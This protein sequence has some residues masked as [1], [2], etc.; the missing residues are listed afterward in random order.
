MAPRITWLGKAADKIGADM[1]A[2]LTAEL[3]RTFPGA[4]G[5][6]VYDCFGGYTQNPRRRIVL[7]VEVRSRNAFHTHVVKIGTRDS[8][9]GDYDGWRTCILRHNCASRIFVSLDKRDLPGDRLAIIYEDA[10]KLFGSAEETQGPQTL[11]TVAFWAIHDGKPDPRSVERVIRQIYTD[12]YRWFYRSPSPDAATALAFYRRRLRRGLPK[13]D[14]ERWRLDLRRDLIWL[15]CGRD[16]PDAFR[17]VNYLDPCEYIAWALHHRRFPQTLVG[18]AHG[19][20]HGRN[21]LV[22]VQRGEAEYPAVF[23]YGEMR[24]TNVLVWDFVK[25]ESELKV[26]FLL[27]LFEDPEARDTLFRLSSADGRWPGM[28]AAAPQ[29]SATLAA[30]SLRAEQLTFSFRF[31]S[32]LA[33]LTDRIYRLAEPEMNDPPG[34]RNIT[35]N[36]RVD[37]ALGILMRIRQEA[38]MFLGGGQSQRGPRGLWQDEYYF[39]LAVYGVASAKF[40]YKHTESAFALV[41]AG[42]AVAHLESARRAVSDLMRPTRPALPAK[43]AR[44]RF[45]YPSY[46]VPLAHA[47]RAWKGR[48]SA[49]SLEQAL[50]LMETTSRLFEHAVP[51]HLE[52][53]LLLAEAGRY[54]EALRMLGP[55]EDICMVFRDEETLCRV[56]RM[57]KELA[58][59]ALE[60]DPRPFRELAMHTAQQWYLAGLKRYREAFTIRGHY[61]PGINAATL[62]RLV[63]NAEESQALAQQVVDHCR[64]LDLS[65]MHVEDCFWVLA[66]QA[67]ANLLLGRQ[68]DAAKVYHQALSML[69]P[70]HRGMAQSA[71]NQVCRLRWAL[72]A[73]VDPCVAMFRA[74]SFKLAPGPLCKFAMA[75]RKSAAAKQRKPARA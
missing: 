9:A 2:L 75:A 31:E 74:T 25:L 48:R 60:E 46:R 56:G 14:T 37:R 34:G 3:R 47:H 50:A 43:P 16:V 63:G 6:A 62:A 5:I 29:P 39:G 61:Y 52:H 13:W 68:E 12:L 54:R 67:E 49:H 27:K 4:S 58:D 20:L 26:R 53:V 71:Y 24:A 45:P 38:A 64:G 44:T 32:V 11:E 69:S 19:D 10:Y 22:G 33:S 42:V 59:R 35:G 73:A 40:D 21:I 1:I 17:D 51:L 55:L 7:G 18:R 70:S 41:S 15:L 30:R 28:P 66:T 36:P 65:S 23:D 8:V 57:C 72:G